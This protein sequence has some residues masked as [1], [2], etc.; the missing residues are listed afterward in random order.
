MGFAN[1]LKKMNNQ[2]DDTASGFEDIPEGIY[3][4]QLVEAILKETKAG[5]LR[6]S[7]QYAVA[8]GEHAGESVFDGFMLEKDNEFCE[9]G[10][11]F[12]KGWLEAIGYE[13]PPL[14]EIED[15]LEQVTA[16]SP[17]VLI[18]VKKKGD[19]TNVRVKELLG[20]SASETQI[21][22]KERTVK[23]KTQS[24]KKAVDCPFSEG[25]EVQFDDDGTALSGKILSI[26]ADETCTILS[27][28]DEEWEEIPFSLLTV[29]DAEVEEEKEEEEEI[30]DQEA[31][32][33][34][35]E[36]EEE[37]ISQEDLLVF[38]GSQGLKEVKKN[39]K[40][41]KII[42]ILEGYEWNADELTEDEVAL[43]EGVEVPVNK[44][45]PKAKAS[46]KK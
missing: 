2:W 45:K 46:K 38:C 22:T 39:M 11:Q 20:G 23:A 19:F 36:E 35:E 24:K 10:A 3:S 29:K 30:E 17:L 43:L 26:D 34:E 25:D 42:S 7:V 28:D 18:E 32:E 9:M 12:M 44:P 15:V 5:A 37:G 8:E 4:A 21:N 13:V 27:D 33:E 6:V 1:R 31:E 40:P 16:D 14:D 41:E